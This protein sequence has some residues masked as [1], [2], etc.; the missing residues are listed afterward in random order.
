MRSDPELL[1]RIVENFVSNAV[2]RDYVMWTVY[3]N[4]VFLD[5]ARAIINVPF[6]CDATGFTAYSNVH[7]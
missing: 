1:A 7:A 5:Q 4:K 2:A 3:D 6:R